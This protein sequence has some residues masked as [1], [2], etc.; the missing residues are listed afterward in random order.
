MS[1]LREAME[2][3]LDLRRKLGSKLC[4]ADGILR[5][6]LAF[7]KSEEASYITTDLA[8]RW[9]RQPAHIQPATWASR[10]RVVRRFAV[11]QSATDPRTEGPPEGPERV[12]ENET[13]MVRIQCL[14]HPNLSTGSW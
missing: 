6:F 9:A 12:N 14:R 11:W 7:A 4:G 8:L 10:L 5:S 2:Q 3:Y 13:L 1:E